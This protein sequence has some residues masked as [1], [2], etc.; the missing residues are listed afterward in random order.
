[1]TDTGR[2]SG[3]ASAHE[4]VLITG[5]AGYVGSHAVLAFRGAGYPVVVVDDLSTGQ[6]SAIPSD[7]AFVEGDVG[8]RSLIDGALARYG[9]GT[10][11]HMAAKASVPD[12]VENPCPYYS[13]NAFASGNLMQA[14]LAHGVKR[15]LFS[16]TAAVYGISPTVPIPESAPTLPISPYGRSKLVT[17]WMLR[18]VAAA[19]GMA[20][21]ALRYFNV[22]GADAAGRA[23]YSGT[24]Q[25]RLFKIACEAALGKRDSVSIWGTDYDTA[26]GTCVRDYVHVSDVADAHVAAIRALEGGAERVSDFVLNCGYGHGTSVREVLDVMQAEARTPFKVELG[27]RRAGDSPTLIADSSRI[28]EVLRWAPRYDDLRFMVRTALAWEA[29]LSGEPL[30]AH[31]ARPE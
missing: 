1:M 23:G 21:M 25:G 18:D 14:C 24:D 28:R 30:P 10:A 2:R 20:C 8:D 31:P 3:G 26:D 9:I 15:F 19:H 22:V 11:V 29:S 13:T 7:V 6:R 27:P 4:P 5:G 12:S 16:S 17:E